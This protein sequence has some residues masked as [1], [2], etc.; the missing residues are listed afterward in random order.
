MKSNLII[1]VFVFSLVTASCDAG[2]QPSVEETTELNIIVPAES[3]A[4]TVVVV[5]PSATPRTMVVEEPA[6]PTPT[7]VAVE[8]LITP[9]VELVD[10]GL[11]HTFRPVPIT[12][13]DSRSRKTGRAA[14]ISGA[15]G[16][17]PG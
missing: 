8:Q 15:V 7:A 14:S 2:A 13:L 11:P 10:S 12:I 3:A 1:L 6:T 5:E 9:T 4:P 16:T 17:Y